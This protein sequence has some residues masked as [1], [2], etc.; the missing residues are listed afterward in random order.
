MSA[1]KVGVLGGSLL[2]AALGYLLFL[3]APRRARARS[4]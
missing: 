3:A 2:S 1:V 4:S